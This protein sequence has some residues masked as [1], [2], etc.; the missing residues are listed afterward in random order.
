VRTAE[1]RGSARDA[2]SLV[3][4]VVHIVASSV[5]LSQD[6]DVA[7]FIKPEVPL[8]LVGDSGRLRQV[9]LNL[10]SNAVKF[11]KALTHSRP[12]SFWSFF[13]IDRV[14]MCCLVCM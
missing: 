11:T 2:R 13:I 8:F 14:L 3:E 9:L 6:L 1:Q 10:L 4:D 12:R 7:F 5:T